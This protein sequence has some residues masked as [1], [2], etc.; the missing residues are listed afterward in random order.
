MD[1]SGADGPLPRA[2]VRAAS[3]GTGRNQEEFHLTEVG[4]G[5][6]ESSSVTREGCKGEG[7]GYEGEGDLPL[8]ALC[9]SEAERVP[10]I[11]HEAKKGD[12]S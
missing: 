12:K 3:S 5:T 7:K 1:S 6:A 9:A 10:E 4:R 2:L 8:D 11:R